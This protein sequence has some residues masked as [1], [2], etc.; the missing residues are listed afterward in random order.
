[1]SDRRSFWTTL[2]GILTGVAA[3]IT[4]VAT[5][6][7]V[8]PESKKEPRTNFDLSPAPQT[9]EPEGGMQRSLFPP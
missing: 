3:I 6:L 7:N 4:A 9:A 8:L 2:P 5:L 1:V